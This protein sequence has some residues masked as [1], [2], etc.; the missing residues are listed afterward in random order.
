MISS[1]KYS[2]LKS[3]F[4]TA[5]CGDIISPHLQDS[6][7]YQP[8]QAGKGPGKGGGKCCGFCC[9]AELAGMSRPSDPKKWKD[10]D[11]SKGTRLIL[12]DPSCS[13]AGRIQKCLLF[14]SIQR[15][16]CFKK[17]ITKPNAVS[18]CHVCVDFG[19]S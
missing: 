15:R 3:C 16:I 7:P 14:F 10:V 8:C 13:L 5:G 11:V 18:G 1:R 4:I 2:D 6:H 19:M 17:N 12:E 9:C